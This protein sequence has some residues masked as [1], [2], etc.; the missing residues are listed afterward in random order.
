MQKLINVYKPKGLTPFQ[1]VKLVREKFPEYKDVKIGYAGRLDPLA[2]G[3][4]LLMI[5]EETTIEK[6]K[7]L[8][9]PKEYEFEVVFGIATDTY[10]ALGMLMSSRATEGSRG[11][12]YHKAALLK[13]SLRSSVDSVG[14]TKK[15]QVFINSKLDRQTQIYPPFSSKT[16][17]GKPLFW[18]ARENRLSEIKI[19]QRE[20][21]IYD[22]KLLEIKEISAVKL[23]KEIMGGRIQSG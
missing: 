15:I 1:V 14:M 22:F 8:N 9:L 11:I 2:H 5:G 12:S 23:K 4:L 10:D 19:P 3:V 13:R 16:V 17:N 20:I 21:E 6:D 7:Y 18:W